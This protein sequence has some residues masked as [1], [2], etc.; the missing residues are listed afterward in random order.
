MSVLKLHPYRSDVQRM[1]W[2]LLV[3]AMPL[4]LILGLSIR[5]VHEGERMVVLRLGRFHQVL[6]PGL[7]ILVL[8]VDATRRVELDEA[9]PE[10]QSLGEEE[11]SARLEHLA[12]AGQLRLDG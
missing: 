3:I 8:G 1:S 4:A 9:L 5:V 2:E 10:W 7:H 11:L 12:K 6:G